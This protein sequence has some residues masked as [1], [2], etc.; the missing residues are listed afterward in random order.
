MKKIFFL[1]CI[2]LFLAGNLVLTSCEKSGDPCGFYNGSQ[3][4]LGPKGGCYYIN[5][6]GNK[7]YVDRGECQC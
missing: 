4:Y 2:N 5:T 1:L 7:E 6:N 3:L